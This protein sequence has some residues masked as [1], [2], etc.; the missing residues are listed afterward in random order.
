MLPPD[1]LR[2]LWILGKTGSGKSTLIANLFAQDLASGQG[3][4]LLDPHGDMVEA[5][6]P[7]LPASRTNQVLLLSPADV[8]HPISFN[9]FR[10]GRNP[11][12]NPALMTSESLSVFRKQWAEFLGPRLEH[13]FRNALLAVASDPRA[14]LLFIYRFLVD[15]SLRKKVIAKVTDPVVRQ[16][17]LKEFA[18]Y[19]KSFQREA[20]S[21]V[22]TWSLCHS[23]GR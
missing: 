4:A 20:L 9:I 14:T 2:H 16:F 21:P 17:W 13:I 7:L 5:V 3:V 6:L 18:E 22:L 11:H 15:E 23:S 1:R 12:P 10:Q 19:P 8:E